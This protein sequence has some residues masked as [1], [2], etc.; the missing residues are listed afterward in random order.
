MP[1]PNEPSFPTGR[2]TQNLRQIE[3]S[4]LSPASWEELAARVRGQNDPLSIKSLEVI[5]DGLKHIEEL[6]ADRKAGRSLRSRFP[7]F[8]SRC[9]RGSRAPTTAPRCSRKSASFTCATSACP[10]SR[11]STSSGRCALAGRRRNCARSARPPPS[12]SSAR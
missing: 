6:N 8:R 4:P 9:S 7:R 11:C 1:P 10:M 3:S 5:I 2:S 12:P